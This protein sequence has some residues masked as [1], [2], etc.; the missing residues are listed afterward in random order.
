[1]ENA[2]IIKVYNLVDSKGNALL[3]LLGVA[4]SNGKHA[5][6]WSFIGHA[7]PMPVRSGTWFNGF[8]A[9]VMLEWLNA[10]GWYVRTEVNMTTGK[11]SVYELPEPAAPKG[12]EK[13]FNRV[14]ARMCRNG[15]KA[16]AALIYQY[17]H[18][19][20]IS[21]AIRAVDDINRSTIA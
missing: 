1:M 18:S 12:N 17:A 6:R 8:P 9:D 20:S 7:I 5:L 2:N 15:Q 14:I 3:L 10:N 19:C 21:E 11:A 16:T 13:V 4:P